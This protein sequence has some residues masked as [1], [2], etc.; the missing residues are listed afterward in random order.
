MAIERIKIDRFDGGI[1]TDTR[2]L[3]DLSRCAHVS[4]F[5]IYT[6]PGRLVPMP[7]Y[8]ADTDYGGSGTGLK[9]FDVRGFWYRAAAERVVAL[10]T[11]TGGATGSAMF[12][13]DDPTDASWTKYSTE[14]SYE[15][16]DQTFFVEVD[17]NDFV[18]LTEN[19]GATYLTHH[20]PGTSV[21]D[22]SEQAYI[23][24]TTKHLT[25]HYAGAD[26]ETYALEPE[27]DL[28]RLE[29]DGT[30]TNPVLTAPGQ[31]TDLT[32]ESTYLWVTGFANQDYNGFAI[33]WDFADTLPTYR[34]DL[35]KGAPRVIEHVGGGVF[36][37]VVDEFM[38]LSDLANGKPG[39]RIKLIEGGS[40]STP[41][42]IEAATHTNAQI[43]P[44]R[45]KYGDRALFYA[46][47]PTD[48]G[49]TTFKEGIWAIGRSGSG[50]PVALSLYL[51][52]SSL[53]LVETHYS[54]GNHHYFAH[55]EDGSVSRLGT[56]TYDE[57]SVYESLVFNCNSNR[58]KSLRGAVVNHEEL[59]SGQSVTIKYRTDLDGSWT[60][61]KTNS[62][63]G[64]RRTS[65]PRSHQALGKFEEIQFRIEVTGGSAGVYSW[66]FDYE[67]LDDLAY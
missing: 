39:M 40:V 50:S 22:N 17:P 25:A 57:T 38:T 56:T 62:T 20:I 13:K 6:D 55:N 19:A 37:V 5:D 46:R 33:A 49:G 28:M 26:S 7:G 10:G 31:F 12:Y 4:H 53:G 64:S 54:F 32:A 1:T 2:N 14:G 3:D 30:L 63:E 44:F 52:T 27:D 23:A 16:R 67:I 24:T 15:L 21:T 65:A 66:S 41:L 9:T 29:T 34:V 60:T 61:L 51:D 47:I 36:A 48:A 35:G 42:F 18:Y 58:N 8:T 59:E 45:Q 43:K 11:K